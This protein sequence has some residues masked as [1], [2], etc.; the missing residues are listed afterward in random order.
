[1]L[2]DI[3]I[4]YIIKYKMPGSFAQMVVSGAWFERLLIILILFLE[5]VTNILGKN[6]R[7]Q[8][9]IS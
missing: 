4:K 9:N 7:I 2:Q 1:M 6:L 5:Y 3:V 8:E